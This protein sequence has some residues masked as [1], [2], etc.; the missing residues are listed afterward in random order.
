MRIHIKELQGSEII[1]ELADGS[2]T[3]VAD[4]KR[5][6]EKISNIPGKIENLTFILTRQIIYC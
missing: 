1:I 5:Q 6:I 2:E 3:T 4:V